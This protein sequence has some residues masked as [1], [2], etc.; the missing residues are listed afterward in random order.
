MKSRTTR[1]FTVA[2]LLLMLITTQAV[3]QSRFKDVDLPEVWQGEQETVPG[4]AWF[5]YFR[6]FSPKQSFLDQTWVLPDIKK[7]TQ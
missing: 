2:V 3:A 4:W 6:F 1:V 5:P 7:A